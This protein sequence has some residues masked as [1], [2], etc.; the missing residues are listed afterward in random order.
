MLIVSE[1]LDVFLYELPS[2]PLIRKV[3]FSI[4][5]VPGSS[6][7]SKAPY[8]MTTVE[9]EELN[10]QLEDILDKEFIHP[11]VSPWGEPV[12]FVRNNYGSMRL[13]IIYK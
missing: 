8:H 10:K 13:C 12:I 11:S 9:L 5:L 7:I 1:Y 6:P 4:D 2:L 3:K